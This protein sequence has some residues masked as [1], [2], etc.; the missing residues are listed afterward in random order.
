[1]TA[2]GR[3][4]CPSQRFPGR[5]VAKGRPKG[6]T[7]ASEPGTACRSGQTR[8]ERGAARRGRAKGAA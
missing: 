5:C 1:M 3:A 6:L 8:G 2:P 4:R 7:D